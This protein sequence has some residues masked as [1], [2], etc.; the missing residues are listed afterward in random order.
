MT[1][2]RTFWRLLLASMTVMMVL[3]CLLAF[4]AAF[5]IAFV[6]LAGYEARW[7]GETFATTLV[8]TATTAL[9]AMV[10]WR[11][12]AVA[13]RVHRRRLHRRRWCRDL[14]RRCCRFDRLLHVRA[15][16]GRVQ[17]IEK[18]SGR[19]RA[20]PQQVRPWSARV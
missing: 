3:H 19:R 7:Y 13:E 2:L 15:C 1:V 11:T 5:G 18:A 4:G 20:A 14:R 16:Q 8:T 10:V 9:L 6:A 17:I 12:A